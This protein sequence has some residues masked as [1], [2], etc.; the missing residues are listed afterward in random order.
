MAFVGN[1]ELILFEIGLV[2]FFG[3]VIPE[4]IKYLTGYSK[5]YECLTKDVGFAPS[6]WVY[7]AITYSIL[8]VFQP[9]AVYRIRLYGNW[10]SGVNL[11]PLVVFWT[12][13]LFFA[14][15]NTFN[16]SYMWLAVIA[17]FIALGL[18]VATTWLFFQLEVL[19][20]VLM[21]VVSVLFFF[22]LVLELAIAFKNRLV[23]AAMCATK[24]QA[25]WAGQIGATLPETRTQLARSTT[26]ANQ[27]R[28]QQQRPASRQP[29]ARTVPGFF[30]ETGSTTGNT[31]KRFA[32]QG[33]LETL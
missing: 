19:A 11:S 1:T 30:H 15:F 5:D 32:K 14:L 29:P 31:I 13:Q 18:G 26:A 8:V 24:E 9:L 33:N 4:V 10:V 28:Q 7:V 23:P 3:I 22:L 21:T 17:G 16:T 27:K 20:G 12:L 25:T 2:G 6:Y